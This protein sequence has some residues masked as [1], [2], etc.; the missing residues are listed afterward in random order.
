MKIFSDSVRDT[1]RLG[2]IIAKNV[3]KGDILC[4]YGQLGSGKTVLA[5]GIAKGLKIKE[6]D[7]VSPTFVLIREYKG[8][9]PFYHF[10][11]YRLQNGEDLAVLGYEEYFY[12]E[13]LSI[14]EWAE[15]LKSILPKG[16]LKVKFYIRGKNKRR[17][18]LLACG[19][20][21]QELLRGIHADIR[22]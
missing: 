21:H 9:I 6:D 14:I 3:K 15:R 22:H 18:E 10:D 1:V 8:K 11:L 12:A 16:H 2:A 17:I 4:F 5:K 20:R 19:R 13:G 7:I